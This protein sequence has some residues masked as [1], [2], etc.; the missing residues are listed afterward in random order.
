MSV[1]KAGLL[2]LTGAALGAAAVVQGIKTYN[3][4]KQL[5]V[6]IDPKPVNN[7]HET[8]LWEFNG[9][10]AVTAD[11]PF[12]LVCTTD[13]IVHATVYDDGAT[14]SI[15]IDPGK[16]TESDILNGLATMDIYPLVNAMGYDDQAF[17]YY[18]T[19]HGWRCEAKK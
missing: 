8:G 4:N 6:T 10:L 16:N 17:D 12:K 18:Q 1:L 19:R 14:I 15:N 3:G 7:P 11:K 5:S 9:E 13:F 2:I